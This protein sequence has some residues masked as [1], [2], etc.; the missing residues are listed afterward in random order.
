MISFSSCNKDS[1]GSSGNGDNSNNGAID[2]VLVGV[3]GKTFYPWAHGMT[4]YNTYT[5]GLY[6]ITETISSSG[7]V[8][9]GVFVEVYR[10]NG[11][12]YRMFVTSNDKG[13][14][15]FNYYTK[16]GA[17]CTTKSL[18]TYFSKKFPNDNYENKPLKDEQHLYKTRVN[19]EGEQQL[20]VK[21]IFLQG[22][23]QYG[24]TID[25]YI[26]N[27]SPIWYVYLPTS[28]SIDE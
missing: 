22:T 10:D 1:S 18:G 8:S 20:V 6:E 2:P 14:T 12:G 25:E 21:P 28:G 17:I 11:T 3:W 26:A 27:G 13:W 5:N 24:W 9:G 4:F 7:Y 16:D 15:T 19:G 23:E